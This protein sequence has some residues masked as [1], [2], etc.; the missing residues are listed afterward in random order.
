MIDVRHWFLLSFNRDREG[1]HSLPPPTPGIGSRTK[2]IRQVSLDPNAYLLSHTVT[3]F[4]GG[5]TSISV[6]LGREFPTPALSITGR[7]PSS[8]MLLKFDACF[9][10]PNMPFGLRSFELRPDRRQTSLDRHSPKGDGG[11]HAIRIDCS[12]PQKWR[13]R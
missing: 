12:I 1:P 6:R 13:S 9:N 2:A 10:P 4:R 3:A 11:S 7:V 8:S 5:I